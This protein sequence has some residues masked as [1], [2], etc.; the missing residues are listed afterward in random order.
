MRTSQGVVQL[1]PPRAATPR[2]RRCNKQADPPACCDPHTAR[3]PPRLAWAEVERQRDGANARDRTRA[4]I[5]RPR[6]STAGEHPLG[7]SG[8]LKLS[9]ERPGAAHRFANTIG[10]TPPPPPANRA[11]ARPHA[12]QRPLSAASS[13]CRAAGARAWR[14]PS[15]ASRARQA[16]RRCVRH[17]QHQP[18]ALPRPPTPPARGARGGGGGRRR[19]YGTALDRPAFGMPSPPHPARAARFRRAQTLRRVTRWLLT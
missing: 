15:S 10:Q 19:L 16:G 9:G 5:A 2:R 8:A 3:A 7:T 14:H 11:C 17:L 13:P 12:T 18:P 6:R 4:P 1:P